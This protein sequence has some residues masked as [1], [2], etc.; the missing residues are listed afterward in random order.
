MYCHHFCNLENKIILITAIYL[1]LKTLVLM[2]INTKTGNNCIWQ[3]CSSLYVSNHHHFPNLYLYFQT[4]PPLFCT[5]VAC[6]SSNSN[7]LLLL[8]RYEYTFHCLFIYRFVVI[9]VLSIIIHYVP[10]CFLMITLKTYSI[11]FIS[12]SLFSFTI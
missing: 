8:K 11:Y 12:I 6:N 7:E 5:N 1:I 9:F 10:M 4:M 2:E 3:Q